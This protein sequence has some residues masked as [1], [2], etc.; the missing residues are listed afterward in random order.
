M[1]MRLRLI[2]S[3]ILVAVFGALA[4]TFGTAAARPSP[5]ISAVSSQRLAEAGITLAA[6][7]PTEQAIIS[8]ATAERL[9]ALQG[10]LGGRTPVRQAVLARV[11]H[12]DPPIDRLCWVVSLDPT[13][14]F[15]AHGPKSSPNRHVAAFFLVYLDA[16]TGQWIF[17]QAG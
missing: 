1:P 9:G 16:H 2:S 3:V 13:G 8:P 7:A 5:S 14:W 4:L 15:H 6:P 11:I 12:S 17:S 10:G